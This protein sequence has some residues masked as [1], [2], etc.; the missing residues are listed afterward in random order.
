MGIFFF[1]RVCLFIVC[2]PGTLGGQKRAS[3][4]E[5]EL[6]MVVNIYVGARN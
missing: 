2:V 3:D 5:L 6:Q 4:L 1:L